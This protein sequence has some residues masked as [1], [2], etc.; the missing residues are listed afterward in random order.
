MVHD[1]RAL[2]RLAQGRKAN[3]PASILDGR[4]LQSTPESGERAGY[5]GAKRKRGSGV[6]NV[7]DAQSDW[8]VAAADLHLAAGAT[9]VIDQAAPLVAVPDDYDGF[10]RPYGPAPDIGADEYVPP[11]TPNHFLYLPWITS[12]SVC[13][14]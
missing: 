3:P 11:F 9:A 10:A 6:G 13:Y 1:L 14:N 12:G 5:D 8:F 4:T 2:L 7:T